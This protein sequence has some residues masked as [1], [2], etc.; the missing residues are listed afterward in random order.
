MAVLV[1]TRG[2]IRAAAL[3]AAGGTASGGDL[4][5]DGGGGSG[6]SGNGTVGLAG[7]VGG[8]II[9]GWRWI[10]RRISAEW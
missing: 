9:L 2:I 1:V 6:G 7:G 4:N 8:A 10:W 3:A 5:I